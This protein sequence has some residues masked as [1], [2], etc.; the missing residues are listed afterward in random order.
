MSDFANSVLKLFYYRQ[1][2]FYNFSSI[3][4][5]YWSNYIYIYIYNIY[6]YIYISDC[7]IDVPLNGHLAKFNNK[8][9]GW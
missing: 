7:L 4:L 3:A 9:V 2:I 1:F 8:K 5:L 6:I